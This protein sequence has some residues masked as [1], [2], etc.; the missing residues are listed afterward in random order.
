MLY[1]CCMQCI[2]HIFN[3]SI[4]QSFH[5]RDSI[6]SNNHNQFMKK[7]NDM[8]MSV[9]DEKISSEKVDLNSMRI[10]ITND[11]RICNSLIASI[12]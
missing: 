9:K 10:M 11:Q 4:V 3:K 2:Q 12:Y 5:L 8:L 6:F 1:V 7:I